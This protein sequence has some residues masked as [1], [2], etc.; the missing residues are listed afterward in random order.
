M[1]RVLEIEC[2]E[3]VLLLLLAGLS[4]PPLSLLHESNLLIEWNFSLC[5]SI[6]LK[7]STSIGCFWHSRFDRNLERRCRW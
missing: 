4:L 5:L 2:R 3:E 6:S 7:G 1:E